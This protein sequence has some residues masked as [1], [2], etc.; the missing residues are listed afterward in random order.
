MVKLLFLEE[1]TMS[2]KNI[3]YMLEHNGKAYRDSILHRCLTIKKTSRNFN[4]IN[5]CNIIIN[6]I[7]EI[8]FREISKE[9]KLWV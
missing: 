7:Y 2:L 5:L 6:I 1:E 4:E 3:R 8:N 9:V